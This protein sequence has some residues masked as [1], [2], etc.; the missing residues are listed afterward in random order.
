MGKLFVAAIA[1]VL[2]ALLAYWSVPLQQRTKVQEKDNN[3]KLQYDRKNAVLQRL[4][5]LTSNGHQPLKIAIGYNSNLDLIVNA[6]QLLKSLSLVPS[7]NSQDSYDTIASME[8]FEKTFSYYMN[9]GSAAERFVEDKAVFN[10]IVSSASSLPE[11]DITYF[12]GGNAAL[13]ANRFASEGCEVLLGG[14]VGRKLSGLLHPQI[15]KLAS[16][17]DQIDEVHLIMEFEKGTKWGT[18]TSPRAN[19]FIVVHDESNS[20]LGVLEQFHKKIENMNPD[21]IVIAGL[22]LLEGQEPSFRTQS[23]QRVANAL[24]KIPLNIPIHLELASIGNDVF[25]RELLTSLYGSFDSLGLNEQELGSVT[26]SFGFSFNKSLFID[27]TLKTVTN[28]LTSI[29]EFLEA[30]VVSTEESFRNLT[31]IH[32][33]TLRYH[34]V[35]HTTCD[36]TTDKYTCKRWNGGITSVIAGALRATQ[37][38]CD[39]EDIRLDDVNILLDDETF[40]VE[41]EPAG[42]KKQEIKV[43]ENDGV[44]E[45]QNCKMKFYMASVLVCEQPKKTVGL[46]DA[47]SATGLVYEFV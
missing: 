12:S 27:P 8:E 20:K 22:H 24:N 28:A 4:L 25:L 38:A 7:N 19:R 45:W 9:R 30:Q 14:V 39:S 2:V 6:I 15:Q 41:I 21:L 23:L 32:L 42:S 18:H 33:H 44:A 3:V 35:T 47:I 31:R 34:V 16:V 26:S 17:E 40:L 10:F 36:E 29:F 43:I 1:V 11:K 46:G 37:Q 5:N 13:M